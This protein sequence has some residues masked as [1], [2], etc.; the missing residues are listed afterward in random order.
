MHTWEVLG[1]REGRGGGRGMEKWQVKVDGS[2]KF[3][4]TW[5][6]YTDG[7]RHFAG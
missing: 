2:N 5:A 7:F 6:Q 1:E 3:T 4:W